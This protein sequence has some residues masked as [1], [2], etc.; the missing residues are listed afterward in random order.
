MCGQSDSINFHW[1]DLEPSGWALLQGGGMEATSCSR[2]P[3]KYSIGS[4]GLWVGAHVA[5]VPDR[6]EEASGHN[7]AH[8]RGF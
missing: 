4:E 7:S 3:G 6:P 5:G 1:S 2:Q 8:S